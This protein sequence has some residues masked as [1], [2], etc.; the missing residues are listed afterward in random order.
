MMAQS[1]KKKKGSTTVQIAVLLKEEAHQVKLYSHQS[2]V[3]CI[4]SECRLNIWVLLH[5]EAYLYTDTWGGRNLGLNVRVRPKV[6]NMVSLWKNNLEPQNLEILKWYSWRWGV[7]GHTL[8]TYSVTLFHTFVTCLQIIS[9]SLVSFTQHQIQQGIL[10]YTQF[11]RGAGK[12]DVCSLLIGHRWTTSKFA[13]VNNGLK[14]H[15]WPPLQ[16]TPSIHPFSTNGECLGAGVALSSIE[17]KHWLL[18]PLGRGLCRD[19]FL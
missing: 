3:G 13:M 5:A 19:I 9:E 2:H 15:S 10:K 14:I 4:M 16:T 11:K 1:S 17:K 18:F 8:N 12:V 7:R 6:Q